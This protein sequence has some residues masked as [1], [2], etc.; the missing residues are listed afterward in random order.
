MLNVIKGLISRSLTE[1]YIMHDN[2][3][4]VNDVLRKYDEMKEKIN[5]L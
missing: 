1:S 4:L 2:L 3:L 5:K